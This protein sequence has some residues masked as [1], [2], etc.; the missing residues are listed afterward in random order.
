MFE[1]LES[2]VSLFDLPV[3]A[4]WLFVAMFLTVLARVCQRSRQADYKR[5]ASLPLDDGAAVEEVK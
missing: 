4:T 3:I 2:Y 5:M 1:E